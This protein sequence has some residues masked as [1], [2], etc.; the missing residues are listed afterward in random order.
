MRSVSFPSLWTVPGV[1]AGLPLWVNSIN[2]FR[3][4]EIQVSTDNTLD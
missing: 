3:E 1:C 4:R 2:Y